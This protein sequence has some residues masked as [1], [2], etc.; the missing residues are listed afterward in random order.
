MIITYSLKY[1]QYQET[2][3][4][5][6]INRAKKLVEKPH[7][8]NKKDQNDPK[9]FI[10]QKHATP[11]G[12]VAKL[13][14]TYLDENQIDQE[15]IYDGFYAVC[16]NLEDDVPKII[17]INK[18]R[19][20]IEECFRIMKSEFKARPVYLSRKERI[21]AHFMTCFAALIIYR[22]LEKKIGEGFTCQEIT[23]TLKNMNMLVSPGDGYIPE[24]TRTDLTD[25][26]HET[27]GFRTDYQIISQRNMKKVCTQ[28]RK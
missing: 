24:Y 23:K 26:L 8:L 25:R 20:E 9:R 17:Q 7:R 19:W 11:D 6:Q 13:T 10:A 2:I 16:T 27:F 3:R 22:I 28:T 12:E 15:K 4:N 5:R 14:V 1:K 18:R 21:T